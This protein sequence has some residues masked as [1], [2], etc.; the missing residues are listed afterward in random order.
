[1]CVGEILLCEGAAFNTNLSLC[2]VKNYIIMCISGM[3][4]CNVD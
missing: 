1:M 2:C 3:I 4:L